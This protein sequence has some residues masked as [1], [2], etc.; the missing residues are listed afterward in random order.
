MIGFSVSILHCQKAAMQFNPAVNKNTAR[1]LRLKGAGEIKKQEAPCGA[2]ISSK[3]LNIKK[4]TPLASAR[5][6]PSATAA[7]V[8]FDSNA[9]ATLTRCVRAIN[10]V[11]PQPIGDSLQSLCSLC[12]GYISSKN[13]HA[14]I[15]YDRIRI[16]VERRVG[17]IK[18]TLLSSSLLP[19]SSSIGAVSGNVPEWLALLHEQWLTFENQLN[20]VRGIFLHLDRGFV[21]QRKDLLSIW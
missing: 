17:E 3:K 19:G 11:P 4:A 13:E 10:A 8:S 5:S 12:E 9:L 6:A 21:L 2:S 15:L 7:S 18:H 1:P 14:S 16:E 20:M